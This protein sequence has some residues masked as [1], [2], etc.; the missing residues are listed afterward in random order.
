MF[1]KNKWRNVIGFL[2]SHQ[3]DVLVVFLL[4]FLLLAWIQVSPTFMDPDAFYHAKMAVLMENEPILGSFPWLQGTTLAQSF[5]DHHWLYH[6]WL[7]PWVKWLP[8]LVGIKLATVFTSS[9]LLTLLYFGL[10]KYRAP[11][12]AAWLAVLLSVYPFLFR[13]SLVKA[14]SWALIFLL[15][16]M[17][18]AM[19]YRYFKVFLIS[20][21]FVWLYGGF[22]ILPAVIGLWL[23]IDIF[24]RSHSD[25]KLA[26]LR[27]RIKQVLIKLGLVGKQQA[28]K[29]GLLLLS[30]LGI[31]G[32]V[33]SHPYWPQNLY[34]YGQQVLDI[35]VRN[36]DYRL[37]N[38]GSEWYP[39]NIYALLGSAGLLFVIMAASLLWILRPR[40]IE[41][42]T[43]FM[44]LFSLI[45]FI[46]TINARRFIEYSA[47]AMVIFLALLWRDLLGGQ[48]LSAWWKNYCQP[49]K[50]RRRWLWVGLFIALL[51]TGRNFYMVKTDSNKGISLTHLQAAAQWLS[52]NTP[53]HSLVVN[54]NWGQWPSLFYYNTNNNYFYGLDP[55]LSLPVYPQGV[56]ALTDLVKDRNLVPPYQLFHDR[57]Q[58]KYILV[59]KK[60]DKLLAKL[61]NN[62]YF[63]PVYSD[64]EAEIFAVQ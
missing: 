39:Y 45:M 21:L 42:A 14:S 15:L 58:A 55:R 12:P 52:M 23:L 48:G 53:D 19:H 4:C 29:W 30:L 64:E 27:S 17:H 61:I 18:W 2:L 20:W 63:L 9:L 34:F 59:D 10:K 25:D 3:L 57:L 1:L 54:D 5:T 7:V 43:V 26:Q 32:G 24:Y 62:V 6:L 47:P 22:L 40:K 13:I 35:A 16:G 44:A 11:W 28:R 41:K 33:I 49:Y 36:I 8:P 37:L 56:L 60:N 38:V 31:I 46:A 51:I 50:S